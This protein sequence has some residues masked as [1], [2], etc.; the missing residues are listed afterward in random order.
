M[1]PRLVP[2]VVLATLLLALAGCAATEGVPGPPRPG[3]VSGGDPDGGRL[4]LARTD[5]RIK[6]VQLH[7]VTNETGLPVLSLG[8]AERLALS[9]DLLDEGTGRPLS[10]YFYH[11][12][13]TW[14]RDLTPSEYL[15][16]FY[17]DDIRDYRTSGATEVDYVHY[18]YEFPNS[19][20]DF[21]LSGNYIVR[22]TEQ[23]NEREVLL[24]RPFFVSEEA[25]E[26]ALDFQSGFSGGASV[27]QPIAQLRPGAQ[28]ANAQ[29]FDYAVCFARN[30][31]F[32]QSRCAQ[33]PSLLGLALYQF[34]LDRTEAFAAE[35][36]FYEVDLGLLQVGPEIANVDYGTVPDLAVLDLDYAR[37]GGN[38]DG[39]ALTGQPVVASVFRGGGRPDTDGEYVTTRFRFVPAGEQEAGGPVLLTG[40]FNA[41]QLDP[42]LALSWN[43]ATGTYEGELL[44]KQ[45]LY[46]YQYVVEDP[47]ARPEALLLQPALY[48]ALVYVRDL[49]RITDRLVAVRSAVS[50]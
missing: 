49:T 17:S 44:L 4:T 37:F 20:I 40:A 47:A 21:L 41:W 11:A 43:P 30:G 36:P 33:D 26:V 22:V 25:A 7:P 3:P 16:S 46:L 34:F 42:A 6:T 50:Q 23:G 28:L 5:D 45:G 13:R 27:V 2:R 15:R 8:S 1:P 10:V 18:T 14:R 24:E 39:V 9:F 48:T 19:N 32:D 12:D 38:V 29:P 31:R 35:R